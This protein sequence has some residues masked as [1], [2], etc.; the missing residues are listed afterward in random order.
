MLFVMAWRNLWRHGR[1]SLLTALAIALG[2]GM[3]MAIIS[4]YDGMFGTFRELMVDRAIGHVQI[5]HSAFPTRRG[6]YDTLPGASELLATIDALPASRGAVARGHG[7]AL[8]GTERRSSG[9]R[10]LGVLPAREAEVTDL[11][12]VVPSTIRGRDAGRFLAS[13]PAREIVLGADLAR[14]LEVGVGGEVVAVTQDA[15]GGIGNEAYTVVGLARSGD[16][17]MDRAGAWIH[18]RDLQELLAIDDRVHEIRVLAASDD[19]ATVSA[20]SGA[21]AAALPTDLVPADEGELQ[22]APWW[23]VDPMAAQL[24]EMRGISQFIVLFVVFGLVALG[25]INTMLMSVIERT[26]ELGVIQALGLRPRGIVGLVLSEAALLGA[27][28]AAIG[29]GIGGMLILYL[30]VVGIE[31]D[32]GDGEGLGFGGVIFP[33]RL[34]GGLSPAVIVQPLIG[35]SISAL[36]AALLPALRAARLRPVDAIRG[37]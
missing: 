14:D 8:L 18:L 7:Q 25:V 37:E 26:R 11:P 9:V 22:I 27:L 19:T 29:V 28:G 5:V 23:E 13:E 15:L 33:T 17:A 20:L 32:V 31:F 2:M 35:V 1:R 30:R 4:L 10:L 21:V 24:F 36:I 6:L 3:T 12:A 16:E 34:Y